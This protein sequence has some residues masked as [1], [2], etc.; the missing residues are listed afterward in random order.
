MQSCQENMTHNKKKI[1]MG[2]NLE[3][4]EMLEWADED[5]K[6]AIL[7]LINMVKDIMKNM[8][9]MR[10]EMKDKKELKRTSRNEK[11]YN[12]NENYSE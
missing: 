8:N 1:K 7:N 5:L 4:A 11:F 2:T 12:W 9:M 3:I 10:I 6:T